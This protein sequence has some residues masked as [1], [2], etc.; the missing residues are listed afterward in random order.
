MPVLSIDS[1]NYIVT[2]NTQKIININVRSKGST[3]ESKTFFTDECPLLTD[4]NATTLSSIFE[5]HKIRQKDSGDEIND[6]L[7]I[8][9][10]HQN[11]VTSNP[12]GLVNAL[13][14]AKDISI[15]SAIA[16]RIIANDLEN[17]VNNENVLH[18][19]S[20]YIDIYGPPLEKDP[21]DFCQLGNTAIGL[22]DCNTK[23]I[24]TK[25]SSMRYNRID[26]LSNDLNSLEWYFKFSKFDTKTYTYIPV[27][28]VTYISAVPHDIVK[29]VVLADGTV[30]KGTELSIEY[31][32][33]TANSYYEYLSHYNKLSSNYISTLFEPKFNYSGL[34][35]NYIYE[36]PVENTSINKRYNDYNTGDILGNLV[37]GKNA[38]SG[39]YSMDLNRVNQ[40]NNWRKYVGL[41]ATGGKVFLK[42][43]DNDTIVAKVKDVPSEKSFDFSTSLSNKVVD[44]V[45]VNNDSSDQDTEKANYQKIEVLDS[46]SRFT[47]S[48]KHKSSLYSIKL[49]N[50]GMDKLASN[51]ELSDYLSKIKRDITNS[52]RNI[53]ESLAPAHT[54]LFGVMF[55]GESVQTLSPIISEPDSTPEGGGGSSRDSTNTALPTKV[56]LRLPTDLTYTYNG[57]VQKPTTNYTYYSISCQNEES[58]NVGT[59]YV[60]YI[61]DQTK[62]SWETGG[63]EPI[64]RTYTIKPAVN[65]RK[66]KSA[67]NKRK[68]KSAIS[69]TYS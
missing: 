48:S 19:T 6:P 23:G 42:Y 27:S 5:T 3:P 66:T 20:A 30:E 60:Q 50:I 25:A 63:S 61:P 69:K 55:G 35:Y 62:A 33:L 46:I 26:R 67:V 29:D 15:K 37:T 14:D 47:N 32:T 17:V 11:S 2:G 21:I 31:R 38:Y 41:G 10:T 16:S 1:I 7:I 4:I 51:S 22:T 43:T 24:I 52:V 53:A 8:T 44:L 36:I 64:I 9:D 54:Q 45:D 49:D 18:Q 68:T 59:Y 12:A 57:T 28:S 39:E 56:K 58:K 65:N 40:I 34:P 13:F